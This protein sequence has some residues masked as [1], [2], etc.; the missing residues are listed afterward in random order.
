MTIVVFLWLIIGTSQTTVS[1]FMYCKETDE[2]DH[3]VGVSKIAF[4]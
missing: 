4:L 1:D 3:Y 2:T